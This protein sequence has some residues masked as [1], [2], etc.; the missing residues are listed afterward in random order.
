MS[1]RPVIVLTAPSGS[2]KTTIARRV[3]E[4]LPQ[5]TFSVSATTR[6]PRDGETDG[7]DYHFLSEEE[8]T[9]RIDAGELI[10][11]EEVYPGRYYGTPR[12][13]IEGRPADPPVLLDIDVKGAANVEKM[14][15]DTAL[16]L[17][18]RP[19]SLEELERRLRNRNTES[20]EA[21]LERLERARLELGYAEQCDY[22]VVNDK[23]EVA[24]AEALDLIRAFLQERRSSAD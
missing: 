6:A 24:V 5:I 19:P 18:I 3:M 10:E 17:F 11:Y 22:V 23:L 14:M 21:L 8:F 9:A 7:V 16:T 13:E 15:G 20:E 1:H 12:S 2:G 4:V